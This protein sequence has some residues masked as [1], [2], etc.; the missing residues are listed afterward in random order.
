MVY[1]FK[2]FIGEELVERTFK[3]FN[4][5][6]DEAIKAGLLKFRDTEGGEYFV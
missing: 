6:K 3:D 1:Y 4:K 5:C 2:F